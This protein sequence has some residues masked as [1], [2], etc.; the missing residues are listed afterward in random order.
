MTDRMVPSRGSASA[1]RASREPSAAARG[2][3]RGRQA[4]AAGE[5]FG[6]ALEELGHDR[7][8][9]AAGAVD[10]LRGHPAQ[11]FAGVAAATL[12]HHAQHRAQGEGEVG[13]GV[14]VGHREHVDAVD[15]VA[16]RDH[17]LDSGGERA[18]Q[19]VA[20]RALSL[21]TARRRHGGYGAECDGL[22]RAWD[23]EW[24]GPDGGGRAGS[25]PGR[26][27]FPARSRDDG[28]TAAARRVYRWPRPTGCCAATRNSPRAIR[29][30]S[31]GPGLPVPAACSGSR[32]ASRFAPRRVHRS[33]A[34]EDMRA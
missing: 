12:A 7:A 27:P 11:H 10:R 16:T 34:Y 2:Q 3:G 8:G 33:G 6:Q 25:G 30:I 1:S 19:G 28:A 15:L 31:H 14:A 4:R 32:Q 17:A 18:A 22:H 23:P 29:S 26:D 13:A 5:A 24:T 20:R 9:I 21:R